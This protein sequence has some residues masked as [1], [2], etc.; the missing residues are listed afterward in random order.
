MCPHLCQSPAPRPQAETRAVGREQPGC[1]S[2]APGGA[3]TSSRKVV[4]TL[5]AYCL[6]HLWQLLVGRLLLFFI[7]V[8][9]YP[10]FQLLT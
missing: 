7:T 3:G 5:Q 4:M 9:I 6:L 10:A 1:N 8:T 2:Q